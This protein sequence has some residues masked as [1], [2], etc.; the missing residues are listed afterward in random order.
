MREHTKKQNRQ[1]LTWITGG[2]D[3][4]YTPCASI[5]ISLGLRVPKQTYVG[6]CG[7]PW[8]FFFLF[9]FF[10]TITCTC[11]LLY[12]KNAKNTQTGNTIEIKHSQKGNT[13]R[14]SYGKLVGRLTRSIFHF[15]R[16]KLTLRKGKFHSILSLLVRQFTCNKGA[17]REA[18]AQQISRGT[19]I[20]TCNRY[21]LS[22]V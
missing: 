18:P 22:F 6:P 21:F 1:S 10:V 4:V 8:R 17:C 16:K 11:I 15:S 5:V 3:V 12:A 20:R 19:Q 13:A 7:T 14:T 2:I 9:F